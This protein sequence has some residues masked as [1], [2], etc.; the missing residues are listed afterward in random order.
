MKLYNLILVL[1]LC[2]GVSLNAQDDFRNAA[3]KAGPAPKIEL[4]EYERFE[5][6]NGLQ[7]IVVENHKLPRVSFQLFVDTPPIQEGEKTGASGLAG[8]LL[9]RG[10]TTKAK[11]EIDEAVDFIGASLNTS[12]T[13]IFA[14]SLTKHKEKVLDLMVDVLYNPAFDEEEFKKVKT[15]TLSALAQSKDDPNA[16]ASNVSQVIRYGKNHPYGGD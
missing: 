2:L 10:T 5:L 1:A 8:Q 13:G 9:G 15:Q 4:G 3:P 11:A 14:A 12:S 16:I 7:V 6:D